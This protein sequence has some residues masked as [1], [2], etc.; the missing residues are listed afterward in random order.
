[1]APL[2]RHLPAAARHDIA[3]PPGKNAARRRQIPM[4][5]LVRP[6]S[7]ALRR[8]LGRLLLLAALACA[9]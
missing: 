5:S 3:R 1:M 2:K 4:R 7:R 6:L 8:P 9:A